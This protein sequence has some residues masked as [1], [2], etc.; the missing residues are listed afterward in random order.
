MSCEY[1]ATDDSYWSINNAYPN[2]KLS[3]WRVCT[4]LLLSVFHL[5]PFS[6]SA[7]L[8]V[9]FCSLAHFHFVPICNRCSLSIFVALRSSAGVFS[10]RW[11]KHK[12]FSVLF[13]YIC[14]HILKHTYIGN[15]E[16]IIAT[17]FFWLTEMD[18]SLSTSNEEE[19]ERPRK[20]FLLTIF[21]VLTKMLIS[22]MRLKHNSSRQF[23]EYFIWFLGI[24][25][26]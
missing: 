12:S 2:H 6:L 7:V 4:S 8:L 14:V 19:H 17:T 1:N 13:L 22:V 24:N 18:S 11:S 3:R 20:F 10:F 16:S 21:V 26:V 15:L 9:S 25:L 5:L 23:E